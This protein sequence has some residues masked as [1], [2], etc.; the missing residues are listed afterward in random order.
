MV[1]TVKRKPYS[2]LIYHFV[3]I[4]WCWWRISRSFAQIKK[5]ASGKSS[6]EI[7]SL[8]R[9]HIDNPT[10]RQIWFY[11]SDFAKRES[12]SHW[13]K[14]KICSYISRNHSKMT[15][16][17]Q[18]CIKINRKHYKSQDRS[19]SLIQG[20]DTNSWTWTSPTLSPSLSS[21]YDALQRNNK[22]KE[23]K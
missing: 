3:F 17:E 11:R 21:I 2:L 18:I 23:E 19:K 9:D 4:P 16:D 14:E 12:L 7:F 22:Q 5:Y 20:F 15:M 8:Y 6:E 1:G 10:W 13:Q